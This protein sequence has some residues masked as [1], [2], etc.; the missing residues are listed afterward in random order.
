MLYASYQLPQNRLTCIR[1]GCGNFKGPGSEMCTHDSKC[2]VPGCP[3]ASSVASVRRNDPKCVKC[4]RHEKNRLRRGIEIS[5][6]EVINNY[7]NKGEGLV[8]ALSV[9][10]H[11]NNQYQEMQQNFNNQLQ[12]LKNQNPNDPGVQLVLSQAGAQLDRSFQ[13]Q[14]AASCVNN[15][16]QYNYQL[17]PYQ[18]H[19]GPL[20]YTAP[21]PYGGLLVSNEPPSA[22]TQYVP[23]G[24][25][26]AVEPFSVEMQKAHAN[27]IYNQ[28]QLMAYN[29]NTSPTETALC[30]SF[31][32]AMQVS[33]DNGEEEQ[34]DIMN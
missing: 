26:M 6:T 18:V 34:V 2:N 24:N 20:A 8:K 29:G 13:A 7:R 22:L 32:A 10:V 16:R 23:G 11:G 27:D 14:F 15:Q 12:N 33:G 3:G 31:Q 25:D 4:Y 21:I 5:T 1:P 30:V 17:Q 19:Q 9:L 28:Q